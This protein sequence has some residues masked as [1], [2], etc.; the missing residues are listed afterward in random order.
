[1]QQPPEQL[2]SGLQ[3]SR[4]DAVASQTSRSEHRESRIG[5]LMCRARSESPK[6]TSRKV[7][8]SAKLRSSVSMP[9]ITRR[10]YN[11][12]VGLTLLETLEDL[13]PKRWMDLEMFDALLSDLQIEPSNS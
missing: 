11:R 4:S 9:E 10:E 7:S 12:M 1:M 13:K 6:Q 2:V 3:T 8:L 5:L